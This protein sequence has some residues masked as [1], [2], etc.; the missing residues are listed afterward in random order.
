M[1]RVCVLWCLG[2][3]GHVLV[4]VNYKLCSNF[5]NSRDV[6]CALQLQCNTLIC[7]PTLTISFF[8]HAKPQQVSGVLRSVLY[9]MFK[10]L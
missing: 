2:R 7:I 10:G 4:L 3:I 6:H 9:L 1:F 5:V 8:R